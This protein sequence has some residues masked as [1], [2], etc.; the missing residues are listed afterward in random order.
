MI[1]VKTTADFRLMAYAAST[2][3]PDR[4][5]NDWHTPTRY[6]EAA[7]QVLGRIDLDPFSSEIANQTVRADRFLTGQKTRFIPATGQIDRSRSG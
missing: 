5:S 2:T 4:D 3:K 7:R 6:I 1:A